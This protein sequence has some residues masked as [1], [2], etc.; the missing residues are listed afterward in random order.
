MTP[1]QVIADARADGQAS[2]SSAIFA[3]A[4][5]VATTGGAVERAAR[6][7][8]DALPRAVVSQLLARTMANTYHGCGPVV[9][10]PHSAEMLAGEG[11]DRG[12]ASVILDLANLALLGAEG[13]ESPSDEAVAYGWA[14]ATL[15]G[16]TASLT[17][18]D[19]TGAS[20]D[21]LAQ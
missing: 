11:C 20:L 3:D 4:M 18:D 13:Y 16:G 7:M 14:I 10:F 9:T 2:P 1:Q 8:V 19:H 15:S 12:L 21:L 17:P 5:T 6:A